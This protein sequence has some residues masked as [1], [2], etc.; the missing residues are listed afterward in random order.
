MCDV[1]LKEFYSIRSDARFCS[2]SCRQA[3]KRSPEGVLAKLKRLGQVF[4]RAERRNAVALVR[5]RSEAESR[6]DLREWRRKVRIWQKTRETKA[7][8]KIRDI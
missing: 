5:P 4:E 7:N 2:A 1:C 6:L 8:K 3:W